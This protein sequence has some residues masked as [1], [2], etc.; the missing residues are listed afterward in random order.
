[1]TAVEG[2]MFI[3]D[4]IVQRTETISSFAAPVDYDRPSEIALDNCMMRPG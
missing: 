3:S 1:M 4:W 2:L